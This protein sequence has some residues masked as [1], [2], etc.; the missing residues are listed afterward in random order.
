MKNRLVL[1]H[2]H[3]TYGSFVSDSIIEYYEN[4]LIVRADL[5]RRWSEEGA[6]KQL[7][8][9]YNYNKDKLLTQRNL[10]TDSNLTNLYSTITYWYNKDMEIQKI[11]SDKFKVSNISD[12]LYNWTMFYEYKSDTIKVYKVDH[13][14]NDKRSEGATFK[15][16]G[17]LDSIINLAS[18]YLYIYDNQ[19]DITKTEYLGDSLDVWSW[20]QDYTYGN[21][22]QPVMNNFFG[23]RINLIL[24]P[25]PIP[26]Y[27]MELSNKYLESVFIH[28]H[29][30]NNII[31]YEY[32]T[33]ANLRPLE[34]RREGTFYRGDVIKYFYN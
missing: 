33:D 31:S 2:S 3:G 13:L 16:K 23:N 12:K 15:I 1:L 32:L 28:T 24:I 10:F 5:Y 7:Y 29:R 22:K 14:D 11:N 8:L 18:N 25:E 26:Y 19:N 30:T 17:S 20:Q 6:Y 4:K 21:E 9:T 27:T 34:L